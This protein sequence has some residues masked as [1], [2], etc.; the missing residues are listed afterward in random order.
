[1]LVFRVPGLGTQS[2]DDHTGVLRAQ[3]AFVSRIKLL[4]GLSLDSAH[5]PA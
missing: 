1:M 3:E 2:C 5:S 4:L